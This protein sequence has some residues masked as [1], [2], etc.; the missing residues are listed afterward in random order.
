M[1]SVLIDDAINAIAAGISQIK[2]DAAMTYIDQITN[3]TD[4]DL[5]LSRI[6]D[7]GWLVPKSIYDKYL[8]KIKE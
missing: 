8:R 7:S 4:G 6:I 1:S 5:V 2:L 3:S